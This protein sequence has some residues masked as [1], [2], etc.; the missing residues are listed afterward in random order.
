MV[1]GNAAVVD[2]HVVD[3]VCRRD[4]VASPADGTI[5]RRYDAV[6]VQV[7]ALRGFGFA[8]PVARREDLL[9]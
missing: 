8:S 1:V 7:D 2:N 6:F 5:A 9:G 4:K 3:T